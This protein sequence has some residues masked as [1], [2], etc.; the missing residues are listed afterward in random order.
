MQ[1]GDWRLVA[2]TVD[3]KL[4]ADRENP[5]LLLRMALAL[6]NSG[7]E[8]EARR[9][10]EQVVIF[11]QQKLPTAKSTR[12]MRFDLA[13]SFR[14][15][16]RSEEAYRYLHEMI[17]NGG[18]PDPVLGANDPGLNLFNADSEFRDILAAINRQNEFKR[19]RILELEKSF[20]ADSDGL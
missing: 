19:A 2:Q 14:L 9:T 13:V 16:N 3:T 15:L 5:N 8:S 4:K 6:H 18:F 10:A 20:S 11:A 17:T 7:Q 12:S 1:L